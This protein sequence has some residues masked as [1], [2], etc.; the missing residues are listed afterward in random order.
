MRTIPESYRSPCP[1][2]GTITSLQYGEKYVLLYTP[3]LPARRILYLIHGGGGDQHSFFCPRF[4][5]MIDHMICD[6]ALEPM[7]IV[8]PTY[9]DPNET[10][11]SPAS[12]G[13]AVAKFCSELRERIIPLAESATGVAFTRNER[14]ISGFSMGG[15]TTWYA[16][17]QALD[18]FY[19]FLPLSGDCWVCGEKGGG[20][21]PDET[22]RRLAAAARDGAPDFRI[23]AI[24]GSQDIAYPNFD[25]QI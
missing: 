23:H 8:S 20:L 14:I 6:R 24:T 22:A 19:W 25:P 7:Y 9:Y 4:I 5:N 11:K 15:V 16:F 21:Y 18:L 2:G 17:L 10:D 13:V 12:S 3:A 1:G